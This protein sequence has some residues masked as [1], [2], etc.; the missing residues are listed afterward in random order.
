LATV[1]LPE[2]ARAHEFGGLAQ[3]LH[4]AAMDA[5]LRDALGLIGH[6]D[7]PPAFLHRQRQR[8]FDI[9]V[10]ACATGI[11]EHDGVPVVGRG[12][13]DGIDVLVVDDT[14]PVLVFDWRGAGLLHGEIHVVLAQVADCSGDLIAMLEE[15]VMDLVAAIAKADVAHSQAVVRAENSAIAE[16]GGGG[17]AESAPG[18]TRHLF[19]PSQR[20]IPDS[21]PSRFEAAC[22]RRHLH[23][24]VRALPWRNEKSGFR[25]C[26]RDRIRHAG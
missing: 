18:D 7:H 6:L 12:D 22:I 16:C 25:C 20:R 15:G 8:L 26:G 13:G 1:T 24:T 2:A 9:D 23:E 21:I 5:D 4:A 10:L 3:R 19:H 14:A 11:D 17:R